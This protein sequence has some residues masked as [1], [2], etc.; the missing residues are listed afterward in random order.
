MGHT[1]E[2]NELLQDICGLAKD[3]FQVSID[4]AD[5]IFWSQAV[6]WGI[7]SVVLVAWV[8]SVGMLLTHVV[9]WLCQ[10]DAYRKHACGQKAFKCWAVTTFLAGFLLYFVGFYWEG[11]KT[12]LLALVFRPVLSSLEM[13]VSHSDLIEVHDPCKENPFYMAAFSLTHFSAVAVSASFAINCFWRRI[14]FW[15]RRKWWVLFPS[16]KTVNI[17][18]GIDDRSL[19]LAHDLHLKAA[20]AG[21]RTLFVDMPGEDHHSAQ[22]LSFS[23]IFGLFSYK[24]EQVRRMAGLRP[25]LMHSAVLPQK[26]EMKDTEHNILDI[27]ELQDLRPV[28]KHA[29]QV[30]L[31]FLSK[32]EHDNIKSML[33]ILQDRAFGDVLPAVYCRA[34]INTV[35]ESVHSV[36]N[37]E[38]HLVD[39]AQLSA[40]ALKMMPGEAG[41][42]RAH[43]IRYVDRDVRLGGVTSP[44]TSLI[45][46]FG[47]TGQDV[48]RFVYEFSA[49]AGTDGQ[50]TPAR[51]VIMDRR[52]D[53]LEAGI[54]RRMPALRAC[55]DEVQLV[56]DDT[57]RQSF[58]DRLAGLIDALNYV[59][60]ALGD[61][62]AGIALAADIYQYAVRHRKGGLDRFG[63]FVRS[64]DAENE[65]RLKRIA[66]FSRDIIVVFGSMGDIYSRQM[67]V[68]N[69][70]EQ[71][72]RKFYENYNRTIGFTGPTWDE[73]REQCRQAGEADMLMLRKQSLHRKEFQDMENCLHAYTKRLLAD[74][75]Y[76]QTPLPL[77]ED[78]S[79]TPSARSGEAEAM[80][81]RC[82]VNLS[83][84]EHLRWNASHQMLGYTGMT[85]DEARALPAGSSCDEIAKKHKYLVDWS[86]LS[87]DTRRFDYA[88]VYTTFVN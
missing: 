67:I 34:R 56:C 42:Y 6:A 66:S 55:A 23:H 76:L 86:A 22:R 65:M 50:K 77:P 13:F 2:H 5:G 73:R 59:V 71:L 52:M 81:H 75:S 14:V 85:A 20:P 33:N 37:A 63:I 64:Y 17:F 58:W 53:E 1:D 51:H 32:S 36:R 24:T 9:Q 62:D 47:D 25:V 46:G 41:S 87:D 61:D 48:F 35:N 88:V 29:A 60:I 30:R 43:P 11:T 15:V 8:V 18:F 27:L 7:L 49:F 31:F 84:G 57:E 39:E 40:D 21:E 44:F 69:G 79:F 54:F 16:E 80:R 4:A 78:F 74:A 10:C 28:L 82:L 70:L 3:T 83:I 12:S 26:V 72:A 45:I 38:I 19:M 68:D